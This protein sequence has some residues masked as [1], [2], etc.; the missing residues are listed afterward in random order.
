MELITAKSKMKPL[1]GIALAAILLLFLA[2]CRDSQDSG[3]AN[4]SEES[5]PG[6]QE[7][8][9]PDDE[10]N[11]SVAET[12]GGEASG[13]SSAAEKAGSESDAKTSQTEPE[14]DDPEHSLVVCVEGTAPS[15]FLFSNDALTAVA[16]R[17]AISENLVT[18]GD[19]AYQAVGLEKLPSL[20]DGDAR[21]VEILVNEGDEVVD[22]HGK[23]LSLRAG[24]TV[25][26][27]AGERVDFAGEPVSMAQLEVDFT[28]KPLNWS[29]GTPVSAVDSEFAFNMAKDPHFPEGRAKTGVTQ[30]YKAVDD[31]TVRW[32]GL[33]GF[34]DQTYFTN[35][36]DPLPA[37]LL[38]RYTAAELPGLNEV[39]RTPLSSGPYVIEEWPD[40]QTVRLVANDNY[41]RAEEGLPLIKNLTIRFGTL[42]EFL[43]ED[44]GCDVIADGA[45]GPQNLD[46]LEENGDLA[47]W[48]VI[49]SPGNVYEQIAYSVLPVSEYRNDRPDWFG[50]ARVRQ[51]LALC[52]DRERMLEEL[53]DGNG[54]IL[55]TLAPS[56][57]PLAPDSLT[58]WSYDPAG[59]N[60]LLDEAGFKDYAGDGR[61]QDVASGIPMTITLG[62]NSEDS[63]RL[64]INEIFQE[65]MSDCSIPVELYDRPA[66]TWFGPGPAGP[67]FGRKFDLATF[68]WL[69]HVNP[70][71]TIF[72]TA[73]IPGPEE[74]D[75]G[76]WD[77]PNV[78]GWSNE[79][80]DLACET[81]VAALPGGEGYEENMTEALRIFNEEL[82][83]L[84]LFTNYKS[85]AV[86]PGVE[87]VALDPTQ[88][89]ILWNIAEWT[90]AE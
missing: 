86:R 32:T 60:A 51:A 2:A 38:S 74:F 29:D 21:R 77:A 63:L 88:T 9:V 5:Y 46:G 82:P 65:N 54:Q 3:P 59:G 23:V 24:V 43:G 44:A 73:K 67:L 18:S 6:V 61:R 83:A 35:V 57:H 70:D 30:S 62:T 19:Y 47:G 27:A 14:E 13:E 85:V 90:L 56:D 50:D 8:A 1:L 89:S 58:A 17:H 45:I 69:G 84:P 71:C 26:N 25:F 42:E 64:R 39:A 53:T 81:A 33:P 7:T 22:I 37:H 12:T 78:S 68:A 48:D 4:P 76:G 10:E 31:L 28:L 72:T 80:Y 55:E 52:T 11:E 41:Y 79:A 20:A 16:L 34:M 49:T 36:W 40:D 66:G 87:N 75:F 15:H